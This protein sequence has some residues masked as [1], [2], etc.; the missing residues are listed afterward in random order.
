[1]YYQWTLIVLLE[2][3]RHVES[4]LRQG[5]LFALLGL[6]SDGNKVEFEPD[7]DSLLGDV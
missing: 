1:M 4:T 2:N 7:Y 3:F 6:A 5:R